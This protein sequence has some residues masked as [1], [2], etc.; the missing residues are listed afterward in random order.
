MQKI[1]KP[2]VMALAISFS[3]IACNN[4]EKNSESTST[5]STTAATTSTDSSAAATSTSQAMDAV[6]VSP[7]LYTVAKDSMGIRV[8]NVVYKPGDSSAMHSHPDNAL[9]VIDGGK[10]EFTGK[11][12]SKQVVAMKSG[13]T[14]I[15][16]AETHTV[17]NV[18]NTTLR[19]ILVEVNRPN[20]AGSQDMTLDATKVASKFY[21]VAQDSLNIRIVMVDYKPGEVSAMHSHPDLAMYVLSPS[22]AEFTEKDG[23]K[24]V[25]TLDK[26]AVMVV[27]ADTHSVKNV[28][29][30]HAKVVLVEVN[31]PQR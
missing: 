21:K 2:A 1:L 9:Y 11:D 15:G 5:D 20:S 26:G 13:M 27:P 22:K 25:M 29:N 30:T 19:A 8:L 18:G 31:R 6:T 3:F 28:G 14:M 12:G 10:A 7:T 24:R 17:K 23:A 16:G 4:E